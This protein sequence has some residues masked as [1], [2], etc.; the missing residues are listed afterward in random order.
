MPAGGDMIKL[1]NCLNKAGAEI[2]LTDEEALFILGLEN[3]LAL[4]MLFSTACALRE[5]YFGRKVFLYGFLYFSTWCRNN[6]SFCGYRALNSGLA[7]YRKSA[8]ELVNAAVGLRDAGVHLL[9]MTM[10]EDPFYCTDQSG[11]QRLLELVRLIKEN[12][13]LPL[14]ISPGTVS[15]EALRLLAEEGV[16]WYACYQETHNRSLFQRLRPQQDYDLRLSRKKDA[17]QLGFLIE[18][19]IL[20]GVGESL[21]DIVHSLRVMGELGA[22]QVRVMS[23]VPQ[24]NTPL[25]HLP[26]PPRSRELKI[27]ALMRL[28][29]PQKL[30]PA[31]LDVDGLAGLKARLEAGAN[32]VTSLIPPRSGLRGVSNSTLD[33]DEGCRTVQSVSVELARL[34]LEAAAPED[35]VNWLAR[36][37][38]RLPKT[39]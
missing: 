26:T 24:A 27:I 2:P 21:R 6:C 14:M 30:I 35:Y 38:E 11:E 13:G 23:F 20:T 25:A 15:R 18:E 3:P 32:V 37:R 1:E 33:I 5:R 4:S 28:L 8:A 19:G 9:D 29:Y 22:E 36:S 12:T 17:R 31:S 39:G 7:R 10:G 34:G 16:D